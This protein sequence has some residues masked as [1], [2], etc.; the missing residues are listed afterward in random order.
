MSKAHVVACRQMTI[1]PAT[2]MHASVVTRETVSIALMLAALNLLEVMETDIMNSYITALC[3]EKIWTKKIKARDPY[4]LEPFTASSLLAGPS[5]S[6]L[7]TAC[8]PWATSH[9]L[10]ILTYGTKPVL[11]MGAMVT[12]SPIILTC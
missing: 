2:N 12:L 3:K 7:L 8:A 9:S 6:T 10:T 4:L 11:R 1:V 5:A